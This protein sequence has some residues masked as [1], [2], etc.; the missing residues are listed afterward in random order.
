MCVNSGVIRLDVANYSFGYYARQLFPSKA[1][2]NLAEKPEDEYKWA[3]AKS[4]IF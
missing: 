4:K 2:Y 3:E 1:D